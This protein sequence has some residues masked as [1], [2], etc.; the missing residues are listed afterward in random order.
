MGEPRIVLGIGMM[1]ISIVLL[2]SVCFYIYFNIKNPD[3]GPRDI[4]HY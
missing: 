4:N 1:G 3:K 2:I